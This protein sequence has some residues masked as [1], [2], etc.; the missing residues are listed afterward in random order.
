MRRGMVNVRVWRS[1]PNQLLIM[2]K[3]LKMKEYAGNKEVGE[4]IEEVGVLAMKFA[5]TWNRGSDIRF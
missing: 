4:G 3:M 1:L 5:Q 2:M